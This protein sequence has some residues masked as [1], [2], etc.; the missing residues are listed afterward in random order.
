LQHAEDKPFHTVEKAQPDEISVNKESE[1]AKKQRSAIIVSAQVSLPLNYIPAEFSLDSA[2][3]GSAQQLANLSVGPAIVAIGPLRE[4]HANVVEHGANEAL[5]WPLAQEVLIILTK[6]TT[7]FAG[8]KQAHMPGRR[9]VVLEHPVHE[10]QVALDEVSV[11]AGI[12]GK[13]EN[14]SAQFI[15]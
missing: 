15:P 1:C 13:R 3:L 10:S 6:L 4:R 14:F 2:G 5:R 12:F 9:K 8:A 7:A 11:I